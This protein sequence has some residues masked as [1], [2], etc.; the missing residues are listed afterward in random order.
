MLYKYKGITKEGKSAKGSIDA[1]T[2]DEAKRKLK[3]K[4]IFYQD[5]REANAVTFKNFSTREMPG[6]MLSSFSKE[7]SSY[8]NSGMAILTA[9]RL[10]EDQHQKEKK[11]ATFLASLRTMIEEGKSLYH[12]LTSQTVYE[13]P[14]FFLQSI[15]VAGQSGKMVSVLIQMGDFFSTQ[16]KIKKQ[17]SNALAYPMFIFV[18][19]IGMVGFLIT[20]VV[21]KITGIFEDTG[22]ELPGITQ[23][24]L[25]ISDFL[26]NNYVELIVGT[27]L[28][29][30]GFKL[31]Y[32][33]FYPYKRFYDA[34]IL[35]LPLIGGLVQNHELG[36]FSYI[37][38]LMLE[39]GI[40]YAHAVKLATS[41][42]GNSAFSETFKEASNRVVEGN[43][44]SYSLQKSKGTKP[45]RNFMQAVA[46]GEESSEV[47]QIL[48]NIAVLYREEN[49][50]KMKLLLSLLEPI[51]M[52]FIGGIVG[53]I[54][55]AM[56][57]P[58][59]SMNLGTNM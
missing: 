13:L 58:I 6:P 33:Y 35:K 54:V 7:F 16:A 34:M 9:I 27:V 28:M 48:G 52:L 8:L 18:V 23:F 15:N 29:I 5:I 26:S 46:L 38:S 22:Q 21:P 4:G 36:R 51:M 24:V 45:K 40:S 11:Y 59:F 47:A 17:V 55:S 37:L 56:L 42:F 39:S 25:T 3:A 31:A 50:D 44:L 10:I 12:A 14:D 53:I 1:S 49:D 32:N 57:L 41:T 43:K 20:F 30:I 19:A 2:L